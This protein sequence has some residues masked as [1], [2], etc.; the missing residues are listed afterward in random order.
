MDFVTALPRTRSRGDT[1]WVIVD[2]LTKS[3]MFIP[4]KETCKK[5]QL[6]K[7]YIRHVLR[8]HGVRKDII[9]NRDSRFLSKL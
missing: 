7:T 9:S 5:K 3:A 1:I 6:V 4:N 8:F 2:R